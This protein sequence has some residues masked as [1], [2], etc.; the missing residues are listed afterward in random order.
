MQLHYDI[1]MDT[2][3]APLGRREKRKQEIR[4]RIEEAA[5]RL[6]QQHGIEDTSIE[7]ICQEADV[8]RRTFY[9]HFTNKHALLGALGISRLYSRS[10]PMLA[11][12]M[13]AQPTTRGRLQAMI[14]YI[15]STFSGMNEI[16]R[17][18]I[19]IGPTAFAEDTEA[20]RELGTSAIDSFTALIRAG[21]ELGEVKQDFSP[22]MLATTVVGTL[23]MLTINWCLDSDY[24]VFAKLEEARGMFEQL[25]CKDTQGA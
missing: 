12:L 17:Q 2:I 7:Q 22:S 9:G 10:E 8:A 3:E 1:F 16:D 14:D 20:Q 18:L 11:E 24:P 6:F 5:Y 4:T 21:L 19:L 15:E 25:I 13:A 23:N